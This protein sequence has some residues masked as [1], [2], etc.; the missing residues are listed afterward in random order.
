MSDFI[1]ATALWL[2]AFVLSF[3]ILAV[4]GSASERNNMPRR[5][6]IVKVCANVPDA[7]DRMRCIHGDGD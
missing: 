2:I 7:D 1:K 4:W 6:E 5:L 3:A